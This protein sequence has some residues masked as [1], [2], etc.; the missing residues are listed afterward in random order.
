MD[1]VKVTHSL[2][3]PLSLY[4]RG[5]EKRMMFRGESTKYLI[6]QL[7]AQKSYCY[8]YN[9]KKPDNTFVQ[10]IP[11]P[12]TFRLLKLETTYII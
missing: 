1:V 3:L 4:F 5:I 11:T 10:K 2:F 9:T 8:L 7:M 6:C 12:R